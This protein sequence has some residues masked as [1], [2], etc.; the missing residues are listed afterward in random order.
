M[1]LAIHDGG[2]AEQ[3]HANEKYKEAVA[4]AV[5]RRA[6][7]RGRTVS[8]RDDRMMAPYRLFSESDVQMRVMLGIEHLRC[9]S[10]S[11]WSAGDII[12][13]SLFGGLAFAIGVFVGTRR[14]IV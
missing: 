11:S 6:R 14:R 7:L 4:V 10:A 13:L 2:N 1:C 12:W 5:E 8:K 3:F 9:P